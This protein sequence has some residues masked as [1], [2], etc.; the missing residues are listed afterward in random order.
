M[1]MDFESN[2]DGSSTIHY[3]GESIYSNYRLGN[4][5]N[6]GTEPWNKTKKFNFL[7]TG[8]PLQSI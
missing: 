7:A 6:S 2:Y 3:C 1:E 4:S 8:I 5:Y